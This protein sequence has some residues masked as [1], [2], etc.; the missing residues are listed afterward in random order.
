MSRVYATK[1]FPLQFRGFCSS[2]VVREC[3]CSVLDCPLLRL[4]P[5]PPRL[6]LRYFFSQFVPS[7]LSLFVLGLLLVVGMPLSPCLRVRAREK[8]K[9]L[10][11][12]SSLDGTSASVMEGNDVI[13][14]IGEGERLCCSSGVIGDLFVER[15]R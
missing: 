5:L 12:I 4:L 13:W 1:V 10:D 7:L 15:V 2:Y 14:S 8:V 3:G 11:R 9:S 6:S